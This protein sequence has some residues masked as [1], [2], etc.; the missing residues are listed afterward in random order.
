MLNPL[1][2][3]YV[4]AARVARLATVDKEARPHAVPV[5]YVYD[6]ERFYTAID[7]KPKVA[8]SS[9]LTRIKN[10]VAN[11]AVTLLI[12]HY[13]DDWTQLSYVQVRGIAVLVT[14]SSER[15][16]AVSALRA[17][18]SQYDTLLEDE[19]TVVRIEPRR[20]VSWSST[21]DL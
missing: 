4:S 20:V 3:A 12:D 13:S 19:A 17:K 7:R 5:C 1:Q 2:E 14:S 6:E 11:P 21:G 9:D 10:L 15:S 16:Q 8:R 18:Y